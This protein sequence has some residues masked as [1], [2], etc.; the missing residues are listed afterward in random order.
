VSDAPSIAIFMPPNPTSRTIGVTVPKILNF[1]KERDKRREKA[2]AAGAC[3]D[4]HS[5]VFV[6][7]DFFFMARDGMKKI[8]WSNQE[9]VTKW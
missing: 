7:Q 9:D 3:I 2:K 5:L 4:P 6:N 8:E 1:I